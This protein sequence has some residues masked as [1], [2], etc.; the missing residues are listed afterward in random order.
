MEAHV[1]NDAWLSR[2]TGTT[3]YRNYQLTA[4]RVT[5]V[6]CGS[7]QYEMSRYAAAVQGTFIV[8]DTRDGGGFSSRDHCCSGRSGC[9]YMESI[10]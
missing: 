10:R 2:A 7:Q 1:S 9:V 3:P 4:A 6:L 5:L 8:S